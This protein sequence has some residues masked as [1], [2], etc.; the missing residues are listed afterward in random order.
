MYSKLNENNHQVDCNRH[1]CTCLQCS[2]QPTFTVAQIFGIVNRV[3]C[4]YRNST[5]FPLLKFHLFYKNFVRVIILSPACSYVFKFFTSKN[6]CYEEKYTGKIFVVR[7]TAILSCC[8]VC[9]VHNILTTS[10]V[11]KILQKLSKA[12]ENSP[13]NHLIGDHFWKVVDNQFSTIKG[14]TA[15]MSLLLPATTGIF[16]MKENSSSSISVEDVF[17]SVYFNVLFIYYVNIFVIALLATFVIYKRIMWKLSK[18]RQLIQDWA[19]NDRS[20]TDMNLNQTYLGIS[21]ILKATE[22]FA[23]LIIFLIMSTVI[24]IQAIVI[25]T[26][27]SSFKHNPQLNLVLKTFLSSALV[28]IFLVMFSWSKVTTEVRKSYSQIY[29]LYYKAVDLKEEMVASTDSKL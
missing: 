28:F 7:S 27:F 24:S 3:R 5:Y 16:V 21:A 10:R 11:E 19:R 20:V 17:C 15:V 2:L 29:L 9:I 4:H 23:S 8:F 25:Y 14:M 1:F 6:F 22:K 13:K 26:L 12:L 18:F